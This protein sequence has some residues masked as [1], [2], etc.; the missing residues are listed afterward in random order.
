MLSDMDGTLLGN[1]HQVSARNFRAIQLLKREGIPFFPATG[2]TRLS[3]LNTAGKDFV[4]LLADGDICKLSGVF[5]QGLVVS[6]RRGEII[7]EGYLDREVVEVMEDFCYRHHLSVVAYAGD[8]ILTTRRS[9]YTDVLTHCKELQPEVIQHPLHL[10]QKH[11]AAVNKLILVAD[12]TVLQALRTGIEQQLH[13]LASITKAVPDMLEI[14]PHGASKGDGVLRLLSHYGLSP[15]E[16]L[17]FGD[18]ENDIEMFQ[19]VQYGVAVANAQPALMKHA[20]C[21]TLANHADGVAHTLEQ[22]FQP[23]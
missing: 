23:A 2:R 18:G 6:G 17:A 19:A 7:H 8:R 20:H 1:D 22:I 9:T 4:D 5:S 12:E 13:G 10:M 15:D 21:T 14:L 16:C 11:G 3:I